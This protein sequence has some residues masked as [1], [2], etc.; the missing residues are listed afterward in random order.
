MIILMVILIPTLYLN[1]APDGNSILISIFFN[2]PEKLKFINF[3][4]RYSSNPGT[5]IFDPDGTSLLIFVIFIPKLYYNWAPMSSL[6]IILKFKNY[7]NPGIHQTPKGIPLKGTTHTTIHLDTNIDSDPP[8]PW[9]PFMLMILIVIFWYLSSI[10]IWLHGTLLLNLI[11]HI[12][13]ENHKYSY[14]M[15]ETPVSILETPV[16]HYPPF[17]TDGQASP[18]Q[19]I[20]LKPRYT[21]NPGT[22]W[23]VQ[24]I[25]LYTWRIQTPPWARCWSFSW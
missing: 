23:S 22:P 21:S 1:L 7:R 2:F 15:N 18:T 17:L 10:S 13:P 25:P 9:T 8:P 6:L 16:N 12:L 5:P 4:P 20:I 3:K 19:L 11:V 24:P 14:I